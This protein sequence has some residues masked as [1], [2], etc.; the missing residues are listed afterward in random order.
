MNNLSSDLNIEVSKIG[1]VMDSHIYRTPDQVDN[2][3]ITGPTEDGRNIIL[4]KIE[5]FI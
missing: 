3:T 5:T 4:R 2:L 1:R